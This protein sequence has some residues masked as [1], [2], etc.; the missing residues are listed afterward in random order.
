MPPI[1]ARFASTTVPATA[2]PQP[3]SH[4]THGPNAFVA[5]VKVV[6]Q[7]GISR[8]S[9]RYANAISSIGTN[10]ITKAMGACSPTASTTNPSVAA[11][12]YTGAVDARPMT[13]DP[14]SPSVPVARPLPSFDAG[15]G[16]GAGVVGVDIEPPRSCRHA[17]ASTP[18][19]TPW[20]SAVDEVGQRARP[21]LDVIAIVELVASAAEPGGVGP[22]ERADPDGRRG[23]PGHGQRHGSDV[24]ES[25]RPG[26]PA[27]PPREQAHDDAGDD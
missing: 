14:K 20:G 7:S 22:D 11:S 16:A 12:E 10:A 23:D 17:Q 13:V 19:A 1:C 8:L 4:P 2:T 27:R 6:P 3:P 9:S 25:T 15:A 21:R 26:R 24:G 18:S 5:Q